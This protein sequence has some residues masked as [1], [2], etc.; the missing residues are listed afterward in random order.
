MPDVLNGARSFVSVSNPEDQM[1][2]VNFNE[3]VTLGLPASVMFTNKAEEM[4][5]GHSQRSGRGG[6]CPL[7]RD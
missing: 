7:R 3:R 1:F 5:V 4:E 6:D 2:V